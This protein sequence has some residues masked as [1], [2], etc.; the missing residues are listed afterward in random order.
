MN[1]RFIRN[2]VTAEEQ[3]ILKNSKVFV[4]GCGGQGGYIIEYLVRLGVGNIVCADDGCFEHSDLNRQLLS[5]P[6]LIGVPKTTCA[7]ERAKRL[8]QDVNIQAVNIRMNEEN[9][10]NLIKGSDLAMDALDSAATRKAL[11]Q[12][13]KAENIPLIHAAVNG[14]WVQAAFLNDTFFL[15]EH[16]SAEPI[17]VMSFVP[18]MAAAVQVS[19]AARYLLGC[20]IDNNLHV[21]NMQTMDYKQYTT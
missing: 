20:P 6:G 21:W 11:F 4:A 19:F 13:A 17:K 10:P 2:P 3:E 8:W 9:L 14:W 15:K 16:P 18:G 7:Y 5:E 12:A 1:D